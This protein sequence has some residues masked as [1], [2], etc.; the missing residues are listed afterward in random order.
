MNNII[1]TN[2]PSYWDDRY[3][4][5]TDEWSLNNP[6]PVFVQLLEDEKF[7]PKNNLLI[8]GSALGHDSKF[9]AQKGLK[10]TGVDFSEYAIAKSREL[11]QGM[12]N[13]PNFL[14]M[15]LFQLKDSKLEFSVIYE[16]TTICSFSPNRLEEF[17]LNV[18]TVLVKGGLFITVLFPLNEVSINPPYQVD[19]QTFND[20]AKKYWKLKYYQKSVNSV[21]PRKN[22]EVLLIYSKV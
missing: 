8:L 15:D 18:D 1:N 9:A 12:D 22:N 20:S 2:S 13:L 6:N 7:I 19:L 21:K 14:C 3:T 5:K 10:V 16:Y 17:L 11:C 4:N